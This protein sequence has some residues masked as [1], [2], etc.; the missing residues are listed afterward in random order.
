MAMPILPIRTICRRWAVLVLVAAAACF[1]EPPQ[2]SAQVVLLVN[3]D[4][5]TAYDIEQ[6][7]RLQQLSTRKMPPRQEIIDLLIDDHLKIQIGKRYSLEIGDNEVDNAFANIARNVRASPEQFA[8]SLQGSGVN[9][10]TLKARLRADL[11]WSQVVRGKFQ[12]SLQVGEKDILLALET[13]KKDDDIG[14]DYTLRP[15]LFIIP[16]GSPEAVFESRK[17]EA[18]A[19]RARFQSCDDGIPFVRA[20]RDIVVRDVIQRNSATLSPELRSALNSV[21]VGHLTTSEVTQDG[22][23]VFAVCGKKQTTA[24]TPEKR[25]IR[26]ELFAER[27]DAQGKRYLKELRRSAMIEY[28]Q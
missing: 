3:G 5:I 17:R 27:F 9:P 16:R 23:Q 20:L 4:P 2:A 13:R 14:F 10:A 21:E 8:K 1:A 19:L 18:E 7:G 15:I 26:D 24:E 11:A 25:K 6:R 22:I 28:K 12:S